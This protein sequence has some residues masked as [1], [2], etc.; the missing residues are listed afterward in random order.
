MRYLAC[1]I[2]SKCYSLDSFLW[3]GIH[4]FRPISSYLIIEVLVTQAKFLE[5]LPRFK[6]L[7]L[8]F[9]F[10]DTYYK[11]RYQKETWWF[12]LFSVFNGISNFMDYLMPKP[13]LKKER[14][15]TIQPI[16][17]GITEFVPSP[18]RI[19]N[20]LAASAE[21]ELVKHKFSNVT[22]LH[23]HP[24]TFKT[25]TTCQRTNH[26]DTINHSV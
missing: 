1:L 12:G 21:F 20:V 3:L 4:V 25:S 5:F 17:K 8:P 11:L 14:S 19:R 7:D 22:T 26:H 23:V 2:L 9:S 6:F 24:T 18:F 16:P 15:G 13:S 10:F